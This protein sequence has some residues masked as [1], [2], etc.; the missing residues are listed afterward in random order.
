M[1]AFWIC[2]DAAR[3]PRIRNA[4]NS[5]K[6]ESVCALCGERCEPGCAPVRGESAKRGLRLS[7]FTFLRRFGGFYGVGR[8]LA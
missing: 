1:R 3:F 6:R 5:V 4:E 7:S 2:V 8:L